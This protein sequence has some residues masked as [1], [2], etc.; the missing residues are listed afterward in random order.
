M[1][2]E[3]FIDYPLSQG[4]F[5]PRAVLLTG[6]TRNNSTHWQIIQ[7]SKIYIGHDNQPIVAGTFIDLRSV[8]FHVG[9]RLELIDAT[10]LGKSRIC[11]T[12]PTENPEGFEITPEE[13]QL[14]EI[15]RRET[16]AFEFNVKAKDGNL[17]SI[18]YLRR[19]APRTTKLSELLEEPGTEGVT[20]VK[21]NDGKV[22][23]YDV[24]RSETFE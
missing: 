9:Q 3:I 2:W 15:I 13:I 7:D 16:L 10:P 17:H 19:N 21:G 12:A 5:A 14:I 18:N 23:H 8:L 24:K 4:W 6:D 22:S 11:L 20:S 1:S